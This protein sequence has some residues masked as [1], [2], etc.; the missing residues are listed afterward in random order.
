MLQPGLA[1]AIDRRNTAAPTDDPI[2]DITLE[3][4]HAY[5][6][7][8]SRW[9]TDACDVAA[10]NLFWSILGVNAHVCQPLQHHLH[11][12]SNSERDRSKVE[13]HGC[14]VAQLSN[15]R[16]QELIDDC[17]AMIQTSSEWMQPL[18]NISG[19]DAGELCR[20]SIT[21]ICM[22]AAS[23]HWRVFIAVQRYAE[24]QRLADKPMNIPCE[25]RQ[26]VARSL[27]K[28]LPLP[29]SAERA[30][31]A[32]ET[33]VGKFVSVFQNDLQA[34]VNDGTA[35]PR[36]W[37][38]AMAI[39]TLLGASVAQVEGFNGIIKSV[40]QKCPNIGLP[41]LD[42]RCHLRAASGGSGRQSNVKLAI[43]KAS[44]LKAIL[45]VVPKAAA[46][47][48]ASRLD[49]YDAPSMTDVPA[50]PP[51]QALLDFTD[52]ALGNIADDALLN[53]WSIAIRKSIPFVDCGY[54]I[55]FGPIDCELGVDVFLVAE[56]YRSTVWLIRARVE[57]QILQPLLPFE[58]TTVRAVIATCDR[59]RGLH[60]KTQGLTWQTDLRSSALSGASKVLLTL[61]PPIV[62]AKG[63]GKGKRSRVSMA[64]DVPAEQGD[65]DE[66]W[67][68]SAAE[69]FLQTGEVDAEL[70]DNPR[71]IDMS[72]EQDGDDVPDDALVAWD[73]AVD[74]VIHE[75]VAEQLDLHIEASLDD[76]QSDLVP[77]DA[78]ISSVAD[79]ASAMRSSWAKAHSSNIILKTIKMNKRFFEIT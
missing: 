26:A 19:D 64:L 61:H 44:A 76:G 9:K 38:T 10:S 54:C 15:G 1:N 17:A 72:K 18:V 12:V 27:L 67:L 43:G 33:T 42:A 16:A 48:E 57:N 14:L 62:K 49:R 69:L 58:F 59:S 50:M 46:Q 22:A 21:L 34:A 28:F 63:K 8:M 35:S 68:R 77:S 65:D 79:R 13:E 11:M 52:R 41:L 24:L 32:P 78:L 30:T 66:L 73:D 6:T 60:A 47:L 5:R 4:L 45:N 25:R 31:V 39:R 71:F 36:M 20:Y 7:K 70:L 74:A 3:E 75:R 51:A 55:F 40:N 2:S 37:S 56:T 23:L 29:N 53:A